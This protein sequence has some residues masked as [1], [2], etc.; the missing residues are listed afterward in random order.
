MTDGKPTTFTKLGESDFFLA[1]A[2]ELEARR[3]GRSRSRPTPSNNCSTR[4]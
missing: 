4:R 2:K 1:V 3:P